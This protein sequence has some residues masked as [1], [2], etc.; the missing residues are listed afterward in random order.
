MDRNIKFKGKL[1]HSNKWI[2]YEGFIKHLD[3]TIILITKSNNSNVE[4]SPIYPE[5]LIEFTGLKDKNGIDIYEGDILT[6]HQATVNIVHMYGSTWCYRNHHAE[7]L[8]LDDTWNP[9]IDKYTSHEKI[10]NVLQNP[11]LLN[12]LNIPNKENKIEENN[13][14][15]NQCVKQIKELFKGV[16]FNP[17]V[18]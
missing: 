1:I 17:N 9:Y 6:N 10:G 7:A 13:E 16:G 15:G 14:Y 12:N 3:G 4:T 5:T 2:E 18:K 8:P 11:E